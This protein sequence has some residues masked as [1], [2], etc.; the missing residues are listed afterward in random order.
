MKKVI[1]I[2]LYTVILLSIGFG[3]GFMY[4][5]LKEKNYCDQIKSDEQELLNRINEYQPSC[6]ELTKKGMP[7][8]RKMGKDYILV[9]PNK[10]KND[11]TVIGINN[12]QKPIVTWYG[13]NLK[14]AI[15]QM[16]HKN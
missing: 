10:K 3:A 1:L 9:I 11:Y 13:A 12:M 5:V 6:H 16:Y 8:V 7:V 15:K 2:S 14:S 4:K